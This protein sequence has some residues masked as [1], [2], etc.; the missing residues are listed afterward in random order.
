M[1]KYSL[2]L[3]LLIWMF[4][5]KSF[6]DNKFTLESSA[7]K[8]N[9]MIP[10]EFT[11]SG[12]DQSPP[13]AWHNVPAKTQSFVLIVE[14]PDA[15]NG[16]WTH[17]LI[18]NIPPNV[19]ELGAGSTPDGAT[20]GVNSWGGKGYRGPCPPLGAHRYVFKLYAID[21]ELDLGEGATR[22]TVLQTITSHVLGTAELVGLY[23]KF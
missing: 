18:F 5:Y 6:A 8:L 9:S 21:K 16:T 12:I 22:D 10:A 23:Q 14:D 19:T 15:P 4:N 17:W 1:K 11:C 3:F 13:L 7:F 20:N 2:I